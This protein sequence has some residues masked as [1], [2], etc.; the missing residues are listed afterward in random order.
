MRFNG[1]GTLISS[2]NSFSALSYSVEQET[3]RGLKR[4]LNSIVKKQGQEKKYLFVF[5]KK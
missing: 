4:N 2:E 5:C 1:D 3:E